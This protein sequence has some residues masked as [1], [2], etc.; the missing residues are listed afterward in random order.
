MFDL[1]R[2]GA[3]LPVAGSI[4]QL[5]EL[6]EHNGALVVEAPPGT[7]KTT[8]VPPALHNHTG[9]KVLVTAPRRVAVRAAARRLRQLS[10]TPEL[11][12]YSMRGEHQPG[13]AVE[14]LTPGVLLRRLLADPEL[15]GVSA[16]AV[17][18]V[19]ERQ[20]DTDLVLGMLIELAQLREELRLVAMSATLDAARYSDLLGGAAILSTPAVTHPLEYEHA[21]HEGRLSGSREFYRHLGEQANRAVARRGES[22]LVFVP[23]VREVEQVVAVTG[24]L[25]LHGR[26]DSREQDAALTPSP[27]PRIVVST[28]VAE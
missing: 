19:H 15:A 1:A 18:E 16:V 14:F 6:I 7:G 2:I 20:L 13:S 28:A 10:G 17:D 3:G 11:V 12:G 27:E 9:G 25:P 21:P 22:A 23:G 26:L 8:L 24:G 5:P 4:G